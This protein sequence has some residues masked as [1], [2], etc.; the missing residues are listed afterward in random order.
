M[1]KE[2]RR[3]QSLDAMKADEYSAWRAVSPGERIRA[4]MDLSIELYGL[5]ERTPDEQRLQRTLICLKRL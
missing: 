2:I 4:A 3:F 1:N 5:K